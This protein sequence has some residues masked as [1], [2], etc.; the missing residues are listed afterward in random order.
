MAH[1]NFDAKMSV[2]F[3]NSQEYEIVNYKK[4]FSCVYSINN[5]FKKNQFVMSYSNRQKKALS[6]MC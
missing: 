2:L 4:K 1:D 5:F 3:L 6:K